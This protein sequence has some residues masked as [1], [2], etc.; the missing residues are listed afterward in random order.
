MGWAPAHAVREQF[1]ARPS[2]AQVGRF[3]LAGAG[4]TVL[5]LGL[6]LL[7]I[8]IAP[9]W[10]AFT[11]SFA[12]TII[13]SAMANGR[14]VFSVALTWL[15]SC[16]Y[17]AVYLLNYLLSLGLLVVA[18]ELLAVP[19]SLAPLPVMICMFPVNFIAERYVLQSNAARP[20]GLP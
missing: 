20:E 17:A 13:V 5:S 8:L 6:Y 7:L 14:Y 12:L 2:L 10:L 3:A 15:G 1:F 19:Q 9:Y 16:L 4:R 18:A 11:I